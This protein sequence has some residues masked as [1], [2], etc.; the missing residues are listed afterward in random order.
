[1][2]I[3]NIENGKIVTYV[4][5]KNLKSILNYEKNI[6]K[7]F[8]DAVKPLNL[9]S[10]PETE[11]NAEK[12]IRLEGEAITDY[13]ISLIWIPD[14]RKVRNLPTE[15]IETLIKYTKR[16]LYDI[17]CE[18]IAL[19][20]AN[21]PIPQELQDERAKLIAEKLDLNSIISFKNGDYGDFVNLPTIL[22]GESFHYDLVNGKYTLG[23]SLDGKKALLS[24]KDNSDITEEDEIAIK[25]IIPFIPFALL[26]TKFEHFVSLE[27]GVMLYHHGT[28]NYQLDDSKKMYITELV[29]YPTTD[30]DE[31]ETYTFSN[32]PKEK[33]QTPLQKIKSIF[34]R[35][36]QTKKDAE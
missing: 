33:K 21:K 31:D 26:R 22:D 35:N 11:F 16:L 17:T 6:P 15:E 4:Q 7:A 36:N 29:P 34:K 27:D 13:L 1:M 14:Y 24:K 12:F 25:T 10:D 23:V 8:I 3:T 20:N 9:S 19:E 5:Q 28:L 2:K 32:H 30:K 18:Q